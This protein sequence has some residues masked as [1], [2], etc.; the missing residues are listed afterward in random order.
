MPEPSRRLTATLRESA[1]TD[2]LTGL[3]NRRFLQECADNLCKG[4]RR[5]GKALALLM[6]DLDFFKQ[7]NDIYESV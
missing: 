2:P 7:V 1:L 6:C 5:R 4:A 3:R